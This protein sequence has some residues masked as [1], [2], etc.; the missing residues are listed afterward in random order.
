MLE[1]ETREIL[2]C[3]ICHGALTEA[4]SDELSEGA[5]EREGEV[6]DLEERLVCEPCERWFPLSNGLPFLL[7]EHEDNL[8]G[9]K[10]N[11][12]HQNLPGIAPKKVQRFK[13]YYNHPSKRGGIEESKGGVWEDFGYRDMGGVVLDIGAGDR[14]ALDTLGKVDRY[15]TMDV[16]PR[17][18]PTVVA[19]AHRLPFKDGS[20][21]SVVARA[22]IEHVEEPER[23]IAEVARVLKPGGV[24]KFSA[25][26]MY[27]IHDAVDYHRFTI[28]AIKAMAERHGFEVMKLTSTGGY[29][30]VLT[31]HVYQGLRMVRDNI[32]A[33]YEKKRFVRGLLRGLADIFGMIIYIPF[34]L[35]LP[36]D[37]KYRKIAKEKQ[38]RI[39]FVKGYGAVYRKK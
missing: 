28:Y 26:F 14:N 30:G 37:T 32:D 19:D 20:F 9:E 15:V 18:Q 6:D 21:D 36:L 31:Q 8:E 11:T 23:V 17:D 27:P 2:A 3:P 29:F 10:L 16:I 7:P 38:G 22:L 13:W 5:K 35:L 1:P 33:K 24:L 34:Y 39:P 4:N 25:P 12:R